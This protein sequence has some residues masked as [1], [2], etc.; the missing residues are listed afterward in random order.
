MVESGKFSDSREMKYLLTSLYSERI[1]GTWMVG[2]IPEWEAG[3]DS[4]ELHRVC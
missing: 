3:T 1:Q 4:G 2:G